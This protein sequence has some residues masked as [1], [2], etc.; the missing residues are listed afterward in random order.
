MIGMGGV[1]GALDPAEWRVIREFGRSWGLAS[2][3]VS[4]Q[5]QR[6][7][8]RE[9]SQLAVLWRGLKSLVVSEVR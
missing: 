3:L 1:D 5:R 7:L 8:P 6:V 2:P 4:A 9:K